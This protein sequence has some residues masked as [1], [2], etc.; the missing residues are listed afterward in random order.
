MSAEGRRLYRYVGP[1]DLAALATPGD[2]GPA[3]RSPAD[4]EAWI[5]AR[6]T[7][8]LGEPFTFVVGADGALRLA[9]RRSEHVACA[10]GGAVLAAGEITFERRSGRW[11]VA[12]ISNQSTGYCPDGDS[13]SA[14]AEALDR[15]GL[16]HP[17]GYTYEVVF[18]RCVSC[19]QVNIV[20]EADFLCVFC[21]EEL[22]REWNVDSEA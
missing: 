20:R 13:W 15:A 8:E 1:T 19:G 5:G 2:G 11:A 21:D 22:P 17:G 10:G 14:L 12:E 4:V 7:A 3:M 6:T 9:A 16:E 18:R